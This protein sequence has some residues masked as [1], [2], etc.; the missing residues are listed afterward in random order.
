MH[1]K[2]Y[3][4]YKDWCEIFGNEGI[5]IDN[6]QGFVDALEDLHS[7]H[8]RQQ[9]IEAPPLHVIQ[10]NAVS[11]TEAQGFGDAVQDL[12]SSKGKQTAVGVSPVHGSFVDVISEADDSARSV[13]QNETSGG[14]SKCHRPSKKLTPSRKRKAVDVTAPDRS[15]EPVV[16]VM[17]DFLKDMTSAC[18]DVL[19]KFNLDQDTMADKS[20]RLLVALGNIPGITDEA[21]V[22]VSY[23]L[24]N[25]PVTMELFL[26]MNGGLRSKFVEMM[27]DGKLL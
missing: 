8:G 3:P 26:N 5:N 25:N 16:Q 13:A 14:S 23:K 10:V 6:P 12:H 15:P 22:L 19:K 9:A 21:Q 18:G 11:A 2:S 20:K 1:F 17:G 4:F 24:V 27:L 7:N